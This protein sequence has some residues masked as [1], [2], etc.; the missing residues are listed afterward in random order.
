MPKRSRSSR[1]APRKRARTRSVARRG[2][3]LGRPSRGLRTSVYLFKR[4]YIETFALTSPPS[5]WDQPDTSA[6]TQQ[7]VFKLSDLHDYSDFVNLFNQF[8]ICGVRMQFYF[9]NSIASGNDQ[10]MMY[11]APNLAGSTVTLDEQ[12]FLD[13]QSTKR[14]AGI[15][16]QARPITAYHKCRQLAQVYGGPTQSDYASFRPRYIS[17]GEPSALHYGANIRIQMMNNTSMANTSVK[18]LYTYLI[19]CRQVN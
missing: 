14:K 2:G 17:T 4:S 6:I 16:G 10:V 19:A 15:T 1:N 13:N 12:Y 9:S 18:V 8:K 7:T 11:I 3:R 5:S